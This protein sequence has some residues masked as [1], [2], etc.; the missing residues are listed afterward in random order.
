MLGNILAKTRKKM[1]G[2]VPKVDAVWVSGPTVPAG[3]LRLDTP[4]WFAWLA[5]PMTTSFSYPVMDGA[6]GYISGYLTVRKETRQ[7]GGVYWSAYRRWQGRVQKVYLGR[8]ERVTLARLQAAAQVLGAT[9]RP[10]P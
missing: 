8:T 4:A 2:I 9:D 3:S 7:R 6:R 5:Q 1:S 10:H